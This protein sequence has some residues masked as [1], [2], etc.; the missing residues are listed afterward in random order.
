MYT[1]LFLSQESGVAKKDKHDKKGDTDDNQPYASF[2]CPECVQMASLMLE[3]EL[4]Y[5]MQRNQ[6]KRSKGGKSRD[7]LYRFN[8]N[9]GGQPLKGIAGLSTTG[10]SLRN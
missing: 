9:N 2:D 4:R 5:Y 7:A 8:G 1:R 3:E 10:V 6:H